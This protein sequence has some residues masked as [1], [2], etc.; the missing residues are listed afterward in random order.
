MLYSRLLA[1]THQ[2]H[3][4]NYAS[5]LGR[6]LSSEDAAVQQ[7]ENR[8]SNPIPLFWAAIKQFGTCGVWIDGLAVD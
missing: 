1:P 5:A 2:H 7:D 6:M 4:A 8:Q 3:L